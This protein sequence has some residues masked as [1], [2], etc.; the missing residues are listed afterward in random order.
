[1]GHNIKSGEE[2]NI[3]SN[4]VNPILN[5]ELRYDHGCGHT[6]IEPASVGLNYYSY[7]HTLAVLY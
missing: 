5:L 6:I 2:T 7:T 3:L 4:A 1:M